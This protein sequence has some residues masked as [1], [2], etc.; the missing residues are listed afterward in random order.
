MSARSENRGR[1]AGVDLFALSAAQIARRRGVSIRS[2]MAARQRAKRGDVGVVIRSD[3]ARWNGL[4]GADL[5]R[6]TAELVAEYHVSKSAVSKARKAAGIAAP[7]KTG[8]PKA[9]AP[10]VA[11][12]VVVA[13]E[14]AVKPAETFADRDLTA[15]VDEELALCAA[16]YV[17]AL[18]VSKRL[19]LPMDRVLAVAESR[20]GMAAK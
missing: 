20:C 7:P 2:V 9:A 6:P 16:P 10:I 3:G 15:A 8:R 17:A 11:P 18:I 5:T 12:R 14:R 4:A 1:L 13:R 19:R